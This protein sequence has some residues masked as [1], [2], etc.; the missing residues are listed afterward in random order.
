MLCKSIDW[1]LFDRSFYSKGIF[2]QTLITFFFLS[3]KIT[4][5]FKT[6][7]NIRNNVYVQLLYT[8]FLVKN[9]C[10]VQFLSNTEEFTCFHN[11]Q[12]W[13][14]FDGYNLSIFFVVV[15]ECVRQYFGRCEPGL[16]SLLLC[17]TLI[18]YQKF[19]WQDNMWP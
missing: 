12:Q 10:Y 11:R 4:V 16:S 7:L 19:G 15:G 18:N 6:T 8:I 5:S 9:Q 2:E 3:N 13:P 1:F 17:S 14:R